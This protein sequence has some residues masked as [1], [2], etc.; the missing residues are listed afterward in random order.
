MSLQN[1]QEHTDPDISGDFFPPLSCWSCACLLKTKSRRNQSQGAPQAA[2]EEHT[3]WYRH[4]KGRSTP[5]DGARGEVFKLG[6][7]ME[8]QISPPQHNVQASWLFCRQ[9]HEEAAVWLLGAKSAI[10]GGYPLGSALGEE[11][12]QSTS[13]H[14]VYLLWKS[15]SGSLMNEIAVKNKCPVVWV[16]L[17]AKKWEFLCTTSKEHLTLCDQFLLLIITHWKAWF[18]GILR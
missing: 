7:Y 18:S 13:S 5:G 1:S 6:L 2:P 12:L 8:T 4:G 9:H 14:A 17:H 16:L 3:H 15:F 11:Q 10:R